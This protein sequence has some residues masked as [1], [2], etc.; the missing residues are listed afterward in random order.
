MQNSMNFLGFIHG[1]TH[2]HTHNTAIHKSTGSNTQIDL[3]RTFCDDIQI[4]IAKCLTT[5]KMTTNNMTRWQDVD[6]GV[7]GGIGADA[8]AAGLL[9]PGK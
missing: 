3:R 4:A 5:M 2:T 6:A 8:N 7:G 9:K 1:H